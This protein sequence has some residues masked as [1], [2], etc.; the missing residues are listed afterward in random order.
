MVVD[1]LCDLYQYSLFADLPIRTQNINQEALSHA[2]QTLKI[3]NQIICLVIY[4]TGCPDR[5]IKYFPPF[6]STLTVPEIRTSL[7]ACQNL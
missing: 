6:H 5:T 7:W 1:I 3:K 2:G 4:Q